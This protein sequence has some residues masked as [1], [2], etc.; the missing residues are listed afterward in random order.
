MMKARS[1]FLGKCLYEVWNSRPS[2]HFDKQWG[3]GKFPVEGQQQRVTEHWVCFQ[4]TVWKAWNGRQCAFFPSSS[5]R[6]T[7]G[8]QLSTSHVF[9]WEWFGGIDE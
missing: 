6:E 8:C 9:F 7:G 5:A 1:I 2:F 3:I 4:A